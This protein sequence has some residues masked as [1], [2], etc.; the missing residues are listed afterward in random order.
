MAAQQRVHDDEFSD[1]ANTTGSTKNIGHHQ[2][3]Q[4]DQFAHGPFSVNSHQPQ[5]EHGCNHKMNDSPS[6][7]QQFIGTRTG[8]ATEKLP[9]QQLILQAQQRRLQELFPLATIPELQSFNLDNY[10]SQ[11]LPSHP[12]GARPPPQYCVP[13]GGQRDMVTGFGTV[14]MSAFEYNY[15]S[16]M[17]SQHIGGI[18]QQQQQQQ[19]QLQEKERVA[20]LTLME[21]TETETIVVEAQG[22]TLFPFTLHKIL[23]NPK[24]SNCIRWS[25]DGQSFCLVDE[26]RIQQ[27][28][29]PRIFSQD[30][31][32]SSFKRKLQAWGFRCC[33]LCYQN[34][35]F[36]R[37]KPQLCQYIVPHVSKPSNPDGIATI[38]AAAVVDDNN[39]KVNNTHGAVNPA[40]Q[41]KSATK[42]SPLR[43]KKRP[44]AA[45]GN[46]H[47]G[48]SISELPVV[49]NCG[50]SSEKQSK[51]KSVARRTQDY[52]S[53]C[54]NLNH[55]RVRR[56][57]PD[58]FE[59][60][61]LD[62]LTGRGKSQW[63]RPG[64]IAFRLIIES[65]AATYAQASHKNNKLVVICTIVNDMR[66]KGYRV[67][68]K[69]KQGRW[70]EV[71]DVVART[72][73]GHALRDRLSALKRAHTTF[74]VR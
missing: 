64:N 61:P 72:K 33:G 55:G 14:P 12:F 73:V 16:A 31:T 56:L 51:T 63:H 28:L 41:A 47:D 23:C 4:Q 59:P 18:L 39:D 54:E 30:T 9:I 52:R 45:I 1:A 5:V 10:W 25:P 24:Y 7:P 42:N 50:M 65:W 58:D 17:I 36:I 22:S 40:D 69:D 6:L 32:I 44:A 20:S 60:G 8:M 71:V 2:N 38:N 68:D 29:L 15:R 70:Y 62:I 43:S 46:E 19:Q 26:N 57:F 13:S 37:D 27:L 34:E 74:Q 49:G 3:G 35:F 48:D 21:K 11:L 67:L 66:G 53:R